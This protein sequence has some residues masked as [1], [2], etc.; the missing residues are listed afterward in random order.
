MLNQTSLTSVL[1]T[2]GE[3]VLTLIGAKSIARPRASESTAPMSPAAIDQDCPGFAITEPKRR[4]AIIYNN[5]SSE[6]YIT[7]QL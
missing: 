1:T 6:M 3:M 2:P 4:I 5:N 7:Y